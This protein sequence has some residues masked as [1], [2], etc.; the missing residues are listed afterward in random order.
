[1]ALLRVPVIDVAPAL[2][3]VRDA[4]R[5]VAVAVNQ[6]CEDIGFLVVT[7]HG[8]DRRSAP[9]VTS[10]MTFQHTAAMALVGWY[11]MV[12]PMYSQFQAAPIRSYEIVRSFD[13]E[14]D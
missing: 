4:K 1:M 11:L 2:A 5:S 6:A 3:N 10:P 7:G 12:P 14:S 13:R 8:I 9:Q